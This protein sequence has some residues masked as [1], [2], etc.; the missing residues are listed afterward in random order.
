MSKKKF[1]ESLGKSVCTVVTQKYLIKQKQK[2]KHF[3]DYELRRVGC[4]TAFAIHK[5]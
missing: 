5:I 2:K 3:A 1:T 4:N